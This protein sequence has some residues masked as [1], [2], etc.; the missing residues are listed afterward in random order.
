MHP[1]CAE[2]VVECDWGDKTAS[3]NQTQKKS[4]VSTQLHQCQPIEHYVRVTIAATDLCRRPCTWCCVHAGAVWRPG[5]EWEWVP[6]GPW[7]AGTT[8]PHRTDGPTA[9]QE[10]R[11]PDRR[12]REGGTHEGDINF[13][14]LLFTSE[15]WFVPQDQ[16]TVFKVYEL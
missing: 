6:P 8:T 3:K 16:R 13:L 2:P 14:F 1:T 5:P 12:D 9:L 10:E 11:G 7:P 15:L 4:H